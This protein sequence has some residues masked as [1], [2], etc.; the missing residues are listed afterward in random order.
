MTRTLLAFFLGGALAF[1]Q[2]PPPETS[3]L[4]AGASY[5][6]ESTPQGAGLLAYATQVSAKGEIW[7]FSEYLITSSKSK[8]WTPQTST[9]TGIWNP[10]KK[11]GFLT[12]GTFYQAGVATSSSTGLALSGGGMLIA[13]PWKDK[14]WTFGLAVQYLSTNSNKQTVYSFVVGRTWK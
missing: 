9:T 1:A 12:L 13:K 4:G 2:T 14:P 5:S 3:W 10:L 11:F 6:Q 8:P 7:S